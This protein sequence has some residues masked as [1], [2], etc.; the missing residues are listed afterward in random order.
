MGE[1]TGREDKTH[2]QFCVWRKNWADQPPAHL[3]HYTYLVGTYI[4][5]TRGR[6]KRH[7]FYCCSLTPLRQK[8]VERPQKGLVAHCLAKG[9]ELKLGKSAESFGL[10][11][12][13]G[14]RKERALGSLA[15]A[16]SPLALGNSSSPPPWANTNGRRSLP[17]CFLSE[18]GGTT[19][20]CCP[21]FKLVVCT[22]MVWD[23]QGTKLI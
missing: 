11:K 15:V 13:S 14:N 2:P 17:E 6:R 9:Q 18:S 20:C 4:H 3:P 10:G 21:L 16:S 1:K 19:G 5:G 7:V 8:E 12:F 23:H 22:Y